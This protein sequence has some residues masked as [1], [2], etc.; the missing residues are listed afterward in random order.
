MSDKG[1]KETAGGKVDRS[2]VKVGDVKTRFGAI[3]GRPTRLT[4]EDAIDAAEA[5]IEKVEPRY[6]IWAEN[7]LNKLATHVDKIIKNRR[8]PEADFDNA[9]EKSN[10]LRDLGDTFDYPVVTRVADSMCELL[11]R[12]HHAGLYNQEALD[13]HM[14]AL[15]LVC[16]PKFKGVQ[17]SAVKELLD[18]LRKLVGRYPS[19]DQ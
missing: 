9:Y 8:M 18:S 5:F 12:L 6:L 19:A 13:T 10:H 16:T 11:A 4:R 17:P 3:A 1:S 7:D 14:A 15:R 2:K